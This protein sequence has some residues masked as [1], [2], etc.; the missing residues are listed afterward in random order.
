VERRRAVVRE[1]LWQFADLLLRSAAEVQDAANDETLLARAA[2]A[3]SARHAAAE[4]T[5]AEARGRF[6]AGQSSYL[7]VLD[8]LRAKQQVE[9][10]RLNVEVN[11]RIAR[12]QLH[13]AFG[14]N[15][16]NQP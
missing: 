4:A 9:R 2:E 13:A 16:D 10:E 8:A 5:L 12:V 1:Q 3:L 15:L 6:T 14:Y 7:D 11:R